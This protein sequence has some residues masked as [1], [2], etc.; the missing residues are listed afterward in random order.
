MFVALT[1]LFLTAL[2]GCTHRPAP[3]MKGH[4]KPINR[5]AETTEAIPL[6]RTYE[7]SPFPTDKTLK[8]MLSR[9]AKDANMT[10]SYQ[11]P[12]DFILHTPVAKIRTRDIEQAVSQLSRIY[13]DQRVSVVV[14]GRQITVR[15]IESSG[16]GEAAADTAET[17]MK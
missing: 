4:W 16:G 10:L 7:F 5:F 9:W 3:D 6:Q 1:T 12:D 15:L 2:L 8:A 13:A 14:E 17:A 11:H